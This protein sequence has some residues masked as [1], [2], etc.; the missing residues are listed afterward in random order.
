[1]L[2]H[3]NFVIMG[4]ELD[5]ELEVWPQRGPVEG[6][7]PSPG[8]ADHTIANAGQDAIG[9]QG[10]L[11]AHIQAPLTTSPGSFSAGQHPKSQPV[12]L[13]GVVATQM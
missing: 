11:L 4:P 3:L 13:H 6:D 1:M 8:P 5:A 10:T 7:S 12:A 2:Q 9:L